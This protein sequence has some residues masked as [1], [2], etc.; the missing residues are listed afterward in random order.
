MITLFILFFFILNSFYL[1]FK[2]K[3]R[4]IEISRQSRTIK[5]NN[6]NIVY[7]FFCIFL[8]SFLLILKKKT[9]SLAS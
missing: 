3:K 4:K 1:F 2:E 7:S 5:K 6:D 9:I 8:Y